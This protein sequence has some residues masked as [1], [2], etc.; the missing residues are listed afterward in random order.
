MFS[1]TAPFRAVR[2]GGGDQADPVWQRPNSSTTFCHCSWLRESCETSRGTRSSGNRTC[3]IELRSRSVTVR[4]WHG[5]REGDERETRER[6]REGE[7]E[8]VC[9]C[10]CVCVR[11]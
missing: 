11:F 7:R 2:G 9:V 5:G 3:V 6:E 8:C 4:S 1:G 10:V